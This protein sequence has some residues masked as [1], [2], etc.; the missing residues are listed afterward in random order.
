MA[1]VE[2]LVRLGFAVMIA[3]EQVTV[4]ARKAEETLLMSGR[5]SRMA[6]ANQMHQD[7]MDLLENGMLARWIYAS[8]GQ[9]GGWKPTR[10]SAS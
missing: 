6:L 10:D 2:E 7:S 5:G 4:A 9:V 8:R 3:R 1:M